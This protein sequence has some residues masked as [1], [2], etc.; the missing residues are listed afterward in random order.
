[1]NCRCSKCGARRTMRHPETYVRV[2]KCANCGSQRWRVDRYRLLVEKRRQPCR[3][4][5]YYP[6][7]HRRGS[8]WCEH[9]TSWTAE[10]AEDAFGVPP[11]DFSWMDDPLSFGQRPVTG[12]EA[13]F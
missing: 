1:M 7:P 9:N 5:S 3:C 8:K 11:P 4:A 6:F 12:D 13:P 2:P 10:D